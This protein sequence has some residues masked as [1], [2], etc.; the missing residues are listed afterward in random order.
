MLRPHLFLTA[1]T[2]WRVTPSGS[3]GQ[4][5]QGSSESSVAVFDSEIGDQ[6]RIEEPRLRD[7]LAAIVG[8]GHTFQRASQAYVGMPPS[9][10][11]FSD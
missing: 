3:G 7:A 6:L 8:L 9:H 4:S 11:G 10:G 2:A 1:P 5:Q